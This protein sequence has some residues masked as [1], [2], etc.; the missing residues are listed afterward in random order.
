MIVLRQISFSLKFI[1]FYFSQIEGKIIYIFKTYFYC[2]RFDDE[3]TLQ[4][5]PRKFNEAVD[6]WTQLVPS[7]LLNLHTI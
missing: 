7:K 3:Y 4:L 2:C 6:K 1:L 5:S